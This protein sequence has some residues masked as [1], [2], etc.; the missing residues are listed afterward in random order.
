[1]YLNQKEI[2]DSYRMFRRLVY[3]CQTANTLSDTR[4]YVISLIE[5]LNTVLD[6]A[7]LWLNLYQEYH[8]EKLL[9]FFM[10]YTRQALVDLESYGSMIRNDNLQTLQAP[11]YRITTGCSTEKILTA[12]GRLLNSMM[13]FCCEELELGCEKNYLSVVVPKLDKD[14]LEVEVLFPKWFYEDGEQDENEQKLLLVARGPV[15]GE[16]LEPARMITALFHEMAHQLRYE[17]REKRNPV[18]AELFLESVSDV[19]VRFIFDHMEN[20]E[21][22]LDVTNSMKTMLS[23]ILVEA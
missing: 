2:K 7:H 1:M 5:Q 22:D 20:G 18:L 13:T 19:I 4:I 9:K 17:P 12:Y 3:L 11:S 8:S 23:D 14:S 21:M 15:T 16:L 10:V 6:S